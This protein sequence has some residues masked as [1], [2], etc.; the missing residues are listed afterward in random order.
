MGSLWLGSPWGRGVALKLRRPPGAPWA[1]S[2][3]IGMWPPRLDGPPPSRCWCDSVHR[4]YGTVFDP[5]SQPPN[6]LV[7]LA[8]HPPSPL[9]RGEGWGEGP[10]SAPYPAAVRSNSC[11]RLNISLRTSQSS[12]YIGCSN[13][14]LAAALKYRN[15][16]EPPVPVLAPITRDTVARCAKRHF[17]NA[18]SRSISFSPSWYNSGALPRFR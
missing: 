11:G 6:C 16:V 7:P 14:W 1:A 2:V 4:R 13:S 18:S 9:V 10:C 3:G 5:V 17:R 15:P 8:P 12:G